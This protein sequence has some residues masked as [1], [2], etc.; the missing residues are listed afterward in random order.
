M[1]VTVVSVYDGDTIF[2]TIPDVTPVLGE[3]IGIRIRG[4]DTPE[5]RGKCEAEKRLA[6][7]ARDYINALIEQGTGKDASSIIELRQVERG[8]YYRLVA[9][10]YVDGNSV[11]ESMLSM[12]IARSYDGQRKRLGWCD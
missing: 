12:N 1:F 3:R 9:D 10:V 6:K 2:V 5:I 8:K 11:A 4:I 7:E